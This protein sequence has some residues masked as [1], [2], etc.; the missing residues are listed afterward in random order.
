LLVLRWQERGGPK[1]AAA[2]ITEGFGTV[3]SSHVVRGQ[4]GGQLSYTWKPS[5]LIVDL[6]FPL[7]RLRD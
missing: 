1:L 4:F 7:E 3:L 2:P 5:G 6:S